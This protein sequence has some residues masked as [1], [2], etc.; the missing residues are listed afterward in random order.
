MSHSESMFA[1][2]WETIQDFE[3]LRGQHR[4]RNPFE[5]VARRAKCLAYH[6]PLGFDG[7]GLKFNRCKVRFEFVATRI[8]KVMSLYVCSNFRHQSERRSRQCRVRPVLTLRT[9]VCA[10]LDLRAVAPARDVHD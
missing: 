4:P 6:R 8:A 2:A 1:L 7:A 3:N 9:A 5:N 10:L